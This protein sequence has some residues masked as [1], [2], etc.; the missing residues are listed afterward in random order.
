MFVLQEIKLHYVE[1]G[2]QTN[3]LILLI[4]GNPDFWFTWR[5]QI[6]YLSKSFW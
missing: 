1:S 4:H 3:P 5:K 2:D 6:P